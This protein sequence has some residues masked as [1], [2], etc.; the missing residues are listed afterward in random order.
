MAVNSVDRFRRRYVYQS[1]KQ[2][3]VIRRIV[4]NFDWECLRGLD[5]PE[6]AYRHF[7]VGEAPSRFLGNQPVMQGFVGQRPSGRVAWPGSR[8]R[9]E[10][11]DVE[12]GGR[13][14]RGARL[15]ADDSAAP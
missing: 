1:D 14:V 7:F 15:D 13:Q 6:S 11:A 5:G 10:Q 2:K 4:A 9:G 3:G 12:T 8:P